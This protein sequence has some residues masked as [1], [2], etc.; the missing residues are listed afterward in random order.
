MGPTNI[1]AHELE[2]HGA[3]TLSAKEMAFNIIGLMLTRSN[4]FGQ[5]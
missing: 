4:Q 5:I 1:V 3:R 2:I